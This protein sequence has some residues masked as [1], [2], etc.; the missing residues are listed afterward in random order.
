MKI[1]DTHADIFSNLYERTIKGE[2]NI[3]QKYHL[4][5]LKKGNV[6]GGIWV[7]Y[8][9]SDFDVEEAVDLALKAYEPYEN[10]FDVVFGLEG[11][12]NVDSI[13][14]LKRLY[15]R[16]VR[17]AMLTWNE[18]NHLATGVAGPK[19]RGLTDLGK[20]FLTFMEEHNMIVDVSHLN[21]KSFYDVMNYVKKPVIASHS[22]S[23]TLSDHRRNLNDEQLMVLKNKG[24]YVG[25]NSARNFVSKE[26]SKQNVEGLVD[27]ILYLVDKL[28]INHVML[29]LD[30]MDYLSDY[31]G[32]NETGLSDNLDD[33]VTHADCQNIISELRKRGMSEQ[34]IEKIAYLNYLTMRKT[35]LG[36]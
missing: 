13:A 34:D 15:D 8:S 23:Y 4:D 35:L 2:T 29:G 22:C 26:R 20:E 25:V 3:F 21:V 5:N 12:R 9:A 30:M 31:G 6:V 32:N 27:H 19:D 17:H 28:D 14:C 33:L 36:Y 24:G 1:Y 11:L 10:Q 7:V 18:E 16:G